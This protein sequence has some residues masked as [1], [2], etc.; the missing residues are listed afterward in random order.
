[1]GLTDNPATSGGISVFTASPNAG[2]W[3]FIAHAPAGANT[4]TIT[5]P[6]GQFFNTWHDVSLSF[7]KLNATWASIGLFVDGVTNSL[8]A[9]VAGQTLNT[10]YIGSIGGDILNREFRCVSL[11]NAA[12]NGAVFTFP[13]TN[14]SETYL[15]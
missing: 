10:L 14:F 2:N 4:A 3:S 6:S 7:T 15:M 13:K 9:N 5:Q 12:P 11:V 8:Q 1:M